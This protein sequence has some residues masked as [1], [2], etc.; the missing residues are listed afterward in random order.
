MKL[1]K[2]DSFTEAAQ[3]TAKDIEKW[4]EK[5]RRQL[6]LI[7]SKN[8]NKHLITRGQFTLYPEIER[9][10]NLR[11]CEGCRSFVLEGEGYLFR[12]SAHGIRIKKLLPS[13][14]SQFSDEQ[15]A[16]ELCRRG[17]NY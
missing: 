13:T 15:L 3:M 10:I 1:Y 16:N 2:A 8:L 11:S 6:E 5:E 9:I 4:D 17:W 14:L 12:N 7:A